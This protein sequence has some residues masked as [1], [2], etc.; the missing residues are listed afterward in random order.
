MKRV[1]LIGILLSALLAACNKENEFPDYKYSTVYFAYQS[2]IRTLVLGED[3]F[4]NTLDNQ[5]K[6]Q[7]MASMGGV[8]ENNKDVT[9]DVVIDNALAQGLK[10]DPNNGGGDVV[11]MPSNYYVLPQNMK[12]TIPAGKVMGGLE[13]QLTDAFFADPRSVRNT[14]VIP[15][16]ITKVAN[17]DSILRGTSAKTGADPRKAGDWNVAPKDYVLYAVKYINPYH[18]AYLRRGVAVVKGNNGNTAL[19]TTVVYRNEFVERDQVVNL[20]TRSL[21]QDTTLLSSRNKGNISVPF[22]LLLNFDAA[23]KCTVSAPDA[24][25][26][27][28]SGGGQFTKKG[29]MWGNEKRD[30]LHLKYQVDFGTTTH[31]ITDTLVVRDRG[32]KFETFAP[33][34]L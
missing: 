32:V 2:P 28:V 11:A 16:R 22:Q 9:L 8:Y 21:T 26:Y 14:F 13:V 29:D 6:I 7:I 27:T 15:V 10:F 24:A 19:D 20:F 5:R 12:I 4:D 23:G 33:T 18:S 31:S 3:V 25:L 1:F 17:A 30:V 34:V